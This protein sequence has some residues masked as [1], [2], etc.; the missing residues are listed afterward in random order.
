MK[1]PKLFRIAVSFI[2]IIVLAIGSL[3]IVSLNSSS[4]KAQQPIRAVSLGGATLSPT[5]I[6]ANGTAFAGAPASATI[7][8][9]VA[10]ST[11]VVN[12]T[13]ARVELTEASNP[14]GVGYTV[15]GGDAD[16]GRT[17]NVPLRGGGVSETIIY[18]ITGTSTNVAGTV[19]FRVNLR[20]AT[21]P[22]DTPPPAATLEA[23]TTLT[24][25]LALTFRR[26]T[27]T[28]GGGGGGGGFECIECC[29][30]DNGFACETCGGGGIGCLGSP[31]IV[32]TA[33]NGFDLTNVTNG[34]NFDLDSDG[35]REERVAWTKANSDDA[36]LALDRNGN[37]TIELGMELFGNFSPQPASGN[38]NGFAA[39]AEFD[40]ERDG[41]NGDG[42]IDAQDEVFSRL[43]LWRDLNHNGISEA[44]ELFTLPQ[45]DIVKIE[46]DYNRSKRTDTNGNEF[47]YR[48]KVWDARSARVGR[49]AW[50]VF[51]RVQ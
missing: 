46:L 21:N 4:V 24:Q 42:V 7:T 5:T 49:W 28:A 18:T 2:G 40:K 23:P 47:R 19:Q 22:A 41:G 36:F 11:Q 8:V 45:L 16:N 27:T 51:L 32:D 29:S 43:K 31:I 13:I 37:G 48:A 44:N 38:L 50:D 3:A 35:Y 20:S 15:S 14:S 30:G 9:S 25:G 17:Y 33:G 39:L 34:V 1:T 12:N 26:Q 10:T 6:S